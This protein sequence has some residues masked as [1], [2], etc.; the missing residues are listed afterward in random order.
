[1]GGMSG[2]RCRW[3]IGLLPGL[4]LLLHVCEQLRPACR[5]AL[6]GSKHMMLC[7]LWAFGQRPAKLARVGIFHMR[8][9]LFICSRKITKY[10]IKSY[11]SL[12]HFQQISNLNE[13]QP[14]LPCCSYLVLGVSRVR[15][16][17][18]TTTTRIS[19]TVGYALATTVPSRLIDRVYCM[20][21]CLPLGSNGSNGAIGTLSGRRLLAKESA[22]TH[23]KEINTPTSTNFQSVC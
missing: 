17:R 14:Q 8:A 5:V 23:D 4:P 20:S 22:H 18:T 11:T 2:L 3:C 6:R 1:M 12:L 13:G 7:C 15:V 21:S 10:I 19:A 9:V 16:A